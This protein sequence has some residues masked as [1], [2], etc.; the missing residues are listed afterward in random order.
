[1]A[2]EQGGCV[3]KSKFSLFKLRVLSEVTTVTSWRYFYL[4]SSSR[5]AFSQHLAHDFA[6][7]WGLHWRLTAWRLLCIRPYQKE[8]SHGIIIIIIIIIITAATG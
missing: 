1:M 2:A 8:R 6:R 7:L 3:E 5:T 4:S